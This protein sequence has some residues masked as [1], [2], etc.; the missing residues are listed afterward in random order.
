M[1]LFNKHLDVR[2]YFCDVCRLSGHKRCNR[3]DSFQEHIGCDHFLHVAQFL[4]GCGPQ[5]K[6][7]LVFCF[8]PGRCIT[9]LT[10]QC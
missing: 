7:G 10:I 3:F 6:D 8:D 1:G 9:F 4:N 5:R 2:H